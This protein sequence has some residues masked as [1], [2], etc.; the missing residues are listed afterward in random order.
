MNLKKRRFKVYLLRHG[1][2]ASGNSFVGQQDLPLTEEGLRQAYSWREV[3]E[4][5]ELDTIYSSDLNRSVQTA[6]IVTGRRKGGLERVPEFREIRLGDWEGLAVAEVALRFPEEWYERGASLAA[7][8]PPGGES[9]QDLKERVIPVFKQIVDETG[10]D[11]LI[12]SHSGVNR[13][14]LCHILGVP[15]GYILRLRQDYCC[16]NV[17]EFG[18]E[19][20]QICV[21]NM[22]PKVD[23]QFWIPLNF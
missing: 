21:V 4:G 13:V 8:R 5:I 9:F 18:G 7:F 16:L 2:I 11:T 12:V 15:L 6:E 17:I 1:E 14:I 19:S 22:R 23:G 10:G 20:F 3:F